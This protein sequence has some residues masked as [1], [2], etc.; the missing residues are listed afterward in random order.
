MAA[1][2][3]VLWAAS[4]GEVDRLAGLLDFGA[5]AHSTAD[6]LFEQLPAVAQGE[7]GSAQKVIATLVAGN[8]PKD[9]SAMTLLRGS[10]SKQDAQLTLRLDHGDG[11]STTN[12]Y[13]FQQA[14]DGWKLLVPA[15][16]MA[17]YQRALVGEPSASENSPP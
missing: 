5:E 17:G 7:Y 14:E 8:F 13:R 10:E 2:E 3:S 15:S 4:H 1:F 11:T 6:A 9:A 12:I 16:V